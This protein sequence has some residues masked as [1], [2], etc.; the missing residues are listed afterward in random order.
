VGRHAASHSTLGCRAVCVLACMSLF[1]AAIHVAPVVC[2]SSLALCGGCSNLTTTAAAAALQATLCW[3]AVALTMRC[4]PPRCWR[5][6]R[7]S[8]RAPGRT[9]H[10]ATP[11]TTQQVRQQT[12]GDGL[13]GSQMIA[14]IS[15]T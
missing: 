5:R 12:D 10:P 13:E 11:A 1:T 7:S 6:Q 4:G 8:S 14:M 3:L 15:Q 9:A 2:C